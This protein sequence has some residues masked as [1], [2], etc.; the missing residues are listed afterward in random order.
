MTGPELFER[1]IALLGEQGRCRP[2]SAAPAWATLT[3][4]ERRAWDELART[5]AQERC[6]LRHDAP[7]VDRSSDGP[8][9]LDTL[10]PLL[11]AGCR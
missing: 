9:D 3:A 4:D 11:G 7:V 10:G 2:P 6:L 8:L 5:A 1:C